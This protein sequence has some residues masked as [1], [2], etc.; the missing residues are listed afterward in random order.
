MAVHLD[1]LADRLREERVQ[2]VIKPLLGD[3]SESDLGCPDLEW[4]R[5]LGLVARDAP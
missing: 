3:S 2:R 1:Q 5:D 4:V